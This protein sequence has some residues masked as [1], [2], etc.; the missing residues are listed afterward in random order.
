MGQKTGKTTMDTL[1]SLT[2]IKKK[3]AS[4]NQIPFMTKNFSKEIMARPRLRNKYLKRK[5]EENRLLYIQQRNKAYS[6]LSLL[7]KAKIN[8]Y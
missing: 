5:T 1:N 6:S 7:R 2:P 3:Y 4:D 8:Y